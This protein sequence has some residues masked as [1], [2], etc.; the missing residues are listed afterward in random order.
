MSPKEKGPEVYFARITV[1][2]NETK[3]FAI[4]VKERMASAVVARIRDAKVDS[5]LQLRMVVPPVVLKVLS[6]VVIVCSG[7]D[8]GVLVLVEALKFVML[9]MHR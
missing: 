3:R 1:G 7:G 9:E 4:D 5:L 2:S 6:V 8:P